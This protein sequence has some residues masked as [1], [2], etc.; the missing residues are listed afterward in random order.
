MDVPKVNQVQEMELLL[1]EVVVAADL[2][3]NKT[4]LIL[5]CFYFWHSQSQPS[6]YLDLPWNFWITLQFHV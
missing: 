5:L 4:L 1:R 6:I 3:E 2:E